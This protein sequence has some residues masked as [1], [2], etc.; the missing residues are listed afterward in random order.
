M[1][2]FDQRG[3][4][5]NREKKEQRDQHV[6]SSSSAILTKILIQIE[7]FYTPRAEHLRCNKYYLSTTEYTTLALN[8]V[9]EKTVG[10]D[11]KPVTP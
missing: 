9:L 4:I 6:E 8:Y 2:R 10:R 7:P 5:E 1:A 11:C 3:I